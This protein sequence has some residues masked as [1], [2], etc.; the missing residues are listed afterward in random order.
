M[1]SSP[2]EQPQL[3]EREIDILRLVATG[4]SNKDIAQKLFISPNTVKVHLRNIFAKIGVT[5]RT[6]ATLYAIRNGLVGEDFQPAAPAAIVEAPPPTPT[7]QKPSNSSRHWWLIGGVGLLLALLLALGILVQAGIAPTLSTTQSPTGIDPSAER[8][9]ELAPLPQARKGLAAVNY[10]DQVYILAGEGP[11]GI[12]S[13]VFRYDPSKNTW[14]SLAPK[15]LPVADA[16]AAVIGEK[17][18]VPGGRLASGKISSALE[19]YDPRHD[20]WNQRADLPQAVAGYALV[21][22]EG[23]LYLFGGWDGQKTSSAVFEYD[24][25]D[26]TWKER[27]SMPQPKA[28]ASAVPKGAKIYIIG[29]W[30]GINALTSMD[31]YYPEREQAGESPWVEAA[32]LPEGRFAGG[33]AELSNQIFLVGGNPQTPTPLG[34]VYN[35]EAERW[36]HFEAAP[37]PIG[38]HLSV[39]NYEDYLVV[40]GGEAEGQILSTQQ[41]CQVIFKVLL[42]II[43]QNQ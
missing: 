27:S 8:W 2:E 7:V 21:S 3:S 1:P 28:Y 32:P 17:I 6:E 5:S 4:A 10:E 35:I 34:L 41:I 36:D 43:K 15:P 40:L 38:S 23:R 9:R 24:P 16:Q 11:Q 33:A 14:E 42:P 18:Y 30:D 19:V 29:G 20:E 37:L 22:L 26:D 25:G 13:E 39:V 31:I 12:T